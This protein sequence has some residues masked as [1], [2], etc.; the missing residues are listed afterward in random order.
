MPKPSK[1]VKFSLHRN[2][3]DSVHIRIEQSFL[4]FGTSLAVM[5]HVNCDPASL[6]VGIAARVGNEPPIANQQRLLEFGQF[7]DTMIDLVP[8]FNTPCEYPDR[9]VDLFSYLIDKANYTRSRK[10]QLQKIWDELNEGEAALQK[11]TTN[12]AFA[13][14]ETYP[15]S[16]FARGIY[17]R[18]DVFKCLTGGAI[19]IVEEQVFHV[20]NSL[21]SYLMKT[22]LNIL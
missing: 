4:G 13:K 16:K 7:V 20:L 14:D 19:K 22:D 10:A 8:E 11:Y 21:R 18:D 1:D 9:Y 15:E 3:A 6:V 5:P 2:F 17:S 12:T